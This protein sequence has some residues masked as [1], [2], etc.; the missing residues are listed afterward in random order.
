MQSFSRNWFQTGRYNLWHFTTTL[1]C[2]FSDPG[3]PWVVPWGSWWHQCATERLLPAKVLL[4]ISPESLCAP[5]SS[6]T[7]AHPFFHSLLCCSGSSGGWGAL[8][9]QLYPKLAPEK[10][11]CCCGLSL[12]WDH[13]SSST[14]GA[15]LQGCLILPL[16]V[17]TALAKGNCLTQ[18]SN[19]KL[20]QHFLKIC[21]STFH[22]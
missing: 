18:G 11:L 8:Q 10:G 12:V 20:D 6:P 22:P 5:G 4:S 14:Q 3:Q 7:T 1:P 16:S 15:P 17:W 21:S 2:L 19:L 13:S 9:H